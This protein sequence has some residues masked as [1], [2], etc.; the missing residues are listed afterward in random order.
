MLGCNCFQSKQVFF[1]HAAIEA[2]YTNQTPFNHQI[3]RGQQQ[4]PTLGSQH[5]DWLAG[6]HKGECQTL[7]PNLKAVFEYCS[8][9]RTN[10]LIPGSK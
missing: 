7:M 5:Q 1:S 6:I 10:S 2:L 4:Q 9:F 8:T 3:K